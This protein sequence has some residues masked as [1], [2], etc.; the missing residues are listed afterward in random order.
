MVTSVSAKRKNREKGTSLLVGVTSLVFLVPLTG[1]TIDVGMI[2]AVKSKLQG[3][4]DGAALAAARA[5]NLGLDKPTETSSAQTNATAWFNANFPYNSQTNVGTWSTFGTVLNAVNVDFNPTINGT[6]VQNMIQISISATTNVPT[7]FMKW[8]HIDGTLVGASGQT[9]RR[10]INAM[11]VLDRSSSMQTTASCPDLINAALQFNGQFVNTRDHIGAVS[12]SDG[13]YRHSA[14]ATGFQTTLGYVDNG[15]TAH[16]GAA[17]VGL[18]N[19]AVQRRY[20]N[21]TSHFRGL[22]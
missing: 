15:G 22:Q 12:F 4:V 17:T 1:L 3:A 20:G 8:F 9:T 6:A 2:Y 18:N 21:G 11:L 14:P 13:V 16:N 7:Y 19:I 10:D 5:L